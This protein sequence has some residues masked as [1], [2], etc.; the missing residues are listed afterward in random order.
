M[1]AG[2]GGSMV[3]GGGDCLEKGDE[4][5]LWGKRNVRK[6]KTQKVVLLFELMIINK[7]LKI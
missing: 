6:N 5:V 1:L 3:T 7:F 2:S 4:A